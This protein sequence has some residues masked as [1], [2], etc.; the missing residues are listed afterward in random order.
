MSKAFLSGDSVFNTSSFLQLLQPMEDAIGAAHR[1]GSHDLR[2]KFGD[3]LEAMKREAH[4]E[5]FQTGYNDGYQAGR[6]DGYAAVQQEQA[7]Y[8]TQFQQD[9]ETNR[10][11]VLEAMNRWYELAE[12]RLAELAVYIAARIVQNE[13][14]TNEEA[15]LAITKEAL[16]EVTNTDEVRIRINPFD[17]PVLTEHKSS[18]LAISPSVRQVEIVEDPT[19]EGGCLIES[20]G[21]A[22]DATIR[23]KIE[24]ILSN[25]R[26]DDL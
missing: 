13:L 20:E 26:G 4:D 22:A 16:A 12:P 6:Q 2:V 10:D 24:V 19:I 15:I 7:S 14:K 23:T 5:G 18:L 25:L 8:M 9:L 11:N 3:E 21:G 1:Q 17:S